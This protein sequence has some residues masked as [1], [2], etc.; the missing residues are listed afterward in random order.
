MVL[1]LTS[2]APYRP[3]SGKAAY[4]NQL[5]SQMIFSGSTADTRQANLDAAS[6]PMVARTFDKEDCA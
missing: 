5:N 1:T 2:C 4:C 3:A 6:A